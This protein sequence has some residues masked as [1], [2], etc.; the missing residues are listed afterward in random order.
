M[1]LGADLLAVATRFQRFGAFAQAEQLYRQILREQPD[2]TEVW[3][4]LGGVCQSLGH[5][6][7]AVKSYRHALVLRPELVPAHNNLG[8]ILMEQ[9]R[10]DEAVGSFREALRLQPDFA[11]SHNNLGTALLDQGRLD[12]A[13]ASCREA[14][15]LK[16]AYPAAC[17]N[18]GRVLSRLGRLDEALACYGKA[19]QL[20]ADFA[21]GWFNLGLALHGLGRHEEA[22]ASWE[23]AS[24]LQPND[25]GPLHELGLLLMDLGR[26]AEAAARF[27]QALRLRPDSAAAYSNLGLALLNLGQAEEA[28]L[29][30]QQALHLQPDLAETHNNLGLALLHLGRAQEAIHSFR[31]ALQFRPDLADA[32]NNLGLA[33]AA[34]GL[35]DDAQNC[36]GRAVQ[37]QPDHVGA[38][39]NLG[40]SY[41]DQG[42]LAEAVAC[43]R[44]ALDARPDDAKTHSNLLL[45]M[46]YQADA[47]PLKILGEAR[48]YA[49]RHAAPLAGAIK[50]HSA[51][52]PGERR[53]RLGY[54]SADYREH[55][56]AYYLEPVLSHHDHQS[57]EIFCYADV[58]HPDGVTQ[59]LQGYADQWRS[60]VG[61]SDTQAAE[62]VRRDGIDLLV[63]LSGHTGGNRLLM[64][65]RKPAPIQVSYLGYLGT[66]GLPT[67][68]YYLTDADTDPPG[69]ADMYYQEQLVYLPQ[70]AFC[71]QPGPAPDVNEGP[72]AAKSGQVTF[73]CLNTVAKLSDEVLILWSRILAAV[74]GSRIL[75]RS[76]AGRQAEER[77]RGTLSNRGISP[78]R[79]LLLGQTATRYDYLKLFQAADLCLDPFPY[80]GVTTTCDSLWM[81]VPVV[82][83]AG[84]MGPSRQGV[85]F[86]RAVALGELIAETPEAYIQM[87]TELAGNLPR[88]AALR[89]GLRERMS[90]SPLM[91]AGGLTRHI[92]ATYRAMWGRYLTEKTSA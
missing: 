1:V 56:A 43:Y 46:H 19:V 10:L 21:Q 72:P 26:P 16:P 9:G 81:G 50:P 69:L 30:F 91:D 66:T 32:H 3:C 70:C 87:A 71:Y 64:F 44:K 22:G 24:S 78:E 37:V 36:Y 51:P 17:N 28:K 82:S 53:L 7:E 45:A 90:R 13:L 52:P 79:V 47:D 35:A 92:E 33:L 20:Q 58:P 2:N 31:Q 74:P 55:P 63:D 80:N 4:R 54:V 62:I 85:R 84:R 12:E 61:L 14:L 8:V 25:P 48:R 41:K 59:R 86:L 5:P 73:A 23:R 6:D 83:L 34:E 42:R 15:R 68:D 76:G 67:I 88:L 27:E 65:A 49:Q 75:L 39:A 11:E 38:L 57:F 89:C 40:N 60:L 18:L 77:V 29:S